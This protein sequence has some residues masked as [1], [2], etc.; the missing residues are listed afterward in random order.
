M[1][2]NINMKVITSHVKIS[3]QFFANMTLQIVMTTIFGNLCLLRVVTKNVL[4]IKAKG[5]S[6]LLTVLFKKKLKK[7]C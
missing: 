7:K 4:D 5:P 2:K 3:R 6:H 1:I